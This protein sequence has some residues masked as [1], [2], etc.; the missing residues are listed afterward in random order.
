MFEEA[1]VTESLQR[2]QIGTFGVGYTPT[3]DEVV[4]MKGK[5]RKKRIDKAYDPVIE[6][7]NIRDSFPAPS[8]IQQSTPGEDD[9]SSTKKKELTLNNWFSFPYVCIPE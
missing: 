3:Q 9:S 4:K 2:I 7:P 8:H 6:I 1:C 5:M